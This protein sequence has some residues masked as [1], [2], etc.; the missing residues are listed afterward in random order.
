MPAEFLCKHVLQALQV[1]LSGV[2]V[3]LPL[4]SHSGSLSGCPGGRDHC[5]DLDAR[6]QMNADS[7]FPLHDV[8]RLGF[9]P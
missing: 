8:F 7:E 4:P 3:M 9:A 1:G 2:I 5:L 6:G